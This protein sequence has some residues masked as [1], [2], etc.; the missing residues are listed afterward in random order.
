[1]PATHTKVIERMKSSM[2]KNNSIRP[3]SRLAKG[4]I[5]SESVYLT[6]EVIRVMVMSQANYSEPESLA[7]TSEPPDGFRKSRRTM[8]LASNDS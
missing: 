2:A 3:I 1:M 7:L 8:K 4:L 6:A 5:S